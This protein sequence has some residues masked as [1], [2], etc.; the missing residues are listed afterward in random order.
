MDLSP[1]DLSIEN[2]YKLLIGSVVPRPIA[3]VSTAAPDGTTNLAPF[4]FFCG[5]S[6]NP[7]SLI[8]CPA[9]NADGSPK[10]TLRNILASSAKSDGAGGEFVVNIVPHALR[11]E[12]AATAEELPYGVSEF[13]LASLERAP[14]ARVRPPL[15]AASPFC[16]ECRALQVIR[17]APNQPSGGNIVIGEVVHIHAH[18]G[19]V[20]DAFRVDPA[21][22]D[23]IGRMAG[24]GYCTTRERFDIPWGRRALDA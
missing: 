5:V 20:S 1:S 11:R 8:F 3:W 12:M 7:M 13:D 19:L 4:S 22:L 23:A 2:R 16:Y 18:E 15:V 24:L 9:N 17:L 10:D 14:A 21:A 6:A